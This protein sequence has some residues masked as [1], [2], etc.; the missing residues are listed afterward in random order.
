MSFCHSM[1][2]RSHCTPASS[3]SVICPFSLYCQ[4]A[5]IPSSARRCISKVRIWTSKGNPRS[6]ITVVC[7]DW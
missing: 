6:D 3:R 4:W 7:S 5:A 2:C 1:T